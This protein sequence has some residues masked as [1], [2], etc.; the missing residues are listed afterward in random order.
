[1]PSEPGRTSCG[2]CVT[3]RGVVMLTFSIRVGIEPA[4]R[5][6]KSCSTTVPDKTSQNSNLASEKIAF[7]LL[8]VADC[9]EP[10]EARS[11]K[12]TTEAIHLAEGK[13]TNTSPDERIA[14]AEVSL[15]PDVYRP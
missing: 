10:Q 6:A 12:K 4:L 2:I 11:G 13:I 9:C 3:S 5:R 14:G 1:M 8:D 15:N 7:G